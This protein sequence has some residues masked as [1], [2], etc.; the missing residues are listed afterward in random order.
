MVSG[1]GRFHTARQR[2]GLGAA[3]SAVAHLL[4]LAG[5]GMLL[6][7]PTGGKPRSEETTTTTTMAEPA[8]AEERVEET[9]SVV[10]M[11]EP[12]APP[13]ERKADGAGEVPRPAP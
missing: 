4:A 9:I 10:P 11:E 12:G 3:L 1:T 8:P 6:A 7:H 13:A 2:V 5:L